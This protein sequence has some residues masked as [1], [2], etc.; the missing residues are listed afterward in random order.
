MDG[1][2]FGH[3][4]GFGHPEG[5]NTQPVGE[6]GLLQDVRQST[7]DPNACFLTMNHADASYV[8]RL[9]LDHQGFC[10]QLC[11]LLQLHYGRPIEEVWRIRYSLSI[12][13]S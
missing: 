10:S 13:A 6:V 8:G 2:P 5:E 7:V 12:S 9:H 4:I 11:E 1:F 3:R